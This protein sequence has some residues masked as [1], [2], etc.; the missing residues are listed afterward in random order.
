MTEGEEEQLEVLFTGEEIAERVDS[1]TQEIERDLEPGT[2]RV[3]G[4][5]GTGTGPPPLRSVH[6]GVKLR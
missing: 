5:P 2:E 4:G 6:K 1:L 3:S